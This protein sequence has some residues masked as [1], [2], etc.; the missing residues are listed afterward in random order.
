MIEKLLKNKK[1]SI[2]NDWVDLIV[3]TYPSE[4]FKFLRSQKNRFGNPVGYTI[5]A[6]A[7]KIFDELI[8]DKNKDRIKEYLNEIIKIRAVQDFLPSQAVGIML[9]LKKIVR[10]EL[11][12]ELKDASSFKE[13]MNVESGIDD[14]ALIAFDLYMEAREKLFQIRINDIKASLQNNGKKSFLG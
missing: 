13:L 4:S 2:V 9:L 5:S 14:I 10:K 12:D 7:E 8:N 11:E 6:N 3:E 1:S